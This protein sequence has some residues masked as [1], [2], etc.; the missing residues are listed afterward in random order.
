MIS[1][2]RLPVARKPGQFQPG[3]SG[4][5]GG[6]PKELAEVIALARSHTLPAIKALA[7]ITADRKA[8]SA[9]RVQAAEAILNRAWG[10]PT[11]PL[12]HQGGLVIQ[13]LTGVPRSPGDAAAD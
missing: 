3:Q 8:S 13:V 9:A 6:K 5:P 11:Q 2:N 7:S 4:N 10:K 12:E 1:D